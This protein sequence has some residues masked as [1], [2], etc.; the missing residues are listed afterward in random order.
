MKIIL[1]FVLF[2]LIC[3]NGAMAQHVDIKSRIKTSGASRSGHGHHLSFP[4]TK[5]KKGIKV[6]QFKS[7]L[8]DEQ[9]LDSIIYELWDFDANQWIVGEKTLYSYSEDKNTITETV[10]SWDGSTSQWVLSAKYESTYD[11]N[12]NI[13]L[14]DDYFWEAT[15]SEWVALA[16]YQYDNTYDSNDNLSLFI[17]QEWDISYNQWVNIDKYEYTFDDH[18]NDTLIKIYGWDDTESQWLYVEKIESS[19]DDNGRFLSVNDYTREDAE[20]PWELIEKYEF[21][22]DAPG[23]SAMIGFDW[24]ETTSEWVKSFKD[25]YTSDELGNI[26][27]YAGHVWYDSQWIAYDK[28]TYYYSGQVPTLTPDILENHI[29]VYPNPATEYVVFDLTKVSESAT[30]ELFGV[31]GKKMFEQKLSVNKQILVSNLPKGL[32]T[33]KVNNNGSRYTGKLLVK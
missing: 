22:Y 12:G 3:S 21:T 4:E 5:S 20:S 26:L 2:F 7:A 14:E 6:N 30:V 19:Y 18:G 32:Y 9:K 15:S 10:F 8:A 27:S 1:S 11:A 25:E 23:I 28:E 31:D 29:R 24:D 33:Y 16:K 13:T 17:E